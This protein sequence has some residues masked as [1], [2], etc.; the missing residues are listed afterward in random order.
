MSLKIL[1]V[2]DEPLAR[3][4]VRMHLQHEQDVEIVGECGN[5]DEAAAA[6]AKEHVDLVF[7]DIRMPRHT[8]FD[9]I[10][11][12]GTD[13]MP[14]VIFTTAYD[15]FAIRAF[16]VNALDY[17][18]KPIDPLLFSESLNRAR[19]ALEQQSM[20]ARTAKLNA[21]LN[22]WQ[23]DDNGSP[24]ASGDQER[25]VVRAH[26]HVHFIRPAD[27]QWVE[28]EGDYI[29]LHTADRSHLLRDTMRNMEQRLTPLGFQRIHRSVIVK[30][31]IIS[32][33]ISNDNGDYQVVISSGQSLKLS[34]NY[35]DALFEKLQYQG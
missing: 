23:A 9:L 24:V 12:I 2:D 14:L 4:G 30:L 25:L 27:I 29:T 17:L 13:N 3:E 1:I 8:G 22:E 20:Q 11:R 35:R 34:R 28:A 10:S 21:L 5:V 32:E 26:G 19:D 16:Q 31:D 15:E 6:L 7:L 33:L 18:L